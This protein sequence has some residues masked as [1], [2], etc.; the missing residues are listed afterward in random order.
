M[1]Q[2]TELDSPLDAVETQLQALAA[3]L[4]GQ[5]A[6]D[7]EAA[8]AALQRALATALPPLRRSAHGAALSPALQRR[9]AR[10]R[11]QV[12]AQRESLARAGAALG[13]TIDVLLP[14]PALRTAYSAAGLSE[15]QAHSGLVR[16]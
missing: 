10:A 11:G 4:R 8:A 15:R 14:R 9:L 13:R 2:M 12:A 1:L 6:E 3:A 16:A 7:I 5:R